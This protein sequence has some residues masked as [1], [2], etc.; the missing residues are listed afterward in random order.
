MRDSRAFTFD[1]FIK[2]EGNRLA[3]AV[4]EAVAETP[5]KAYNPLF[6]HGDVGLGK[7]HLLHAIAHAA[8]ERQNA[9]AIYV[10]SERFTIDLTQAIHQKRN[11]EFRNVYRQADILLLDDVHF[12][13]NKRGIS[14]E[15][16]HT[17]NAL[18]ERGHQIVLSSDR[19]PDELTTMQSR[20]VSRF[21]GG[22]VADIRPPDYDIRL[23][24]LRAKAA[25]N[26]FQVSEDLLEQIARRVTSNVRA[27]E[28]ALIR[29]VA[30]ADLCGQPLT[31]DQAAQLIPDDDRDVRPL[32]L[33]VIKV[34]VAKHYRLNPD[35][36][37][38]KR[39]DRTSTHVRQIAMYLARELTD[40]SYPAI[41]QAFGGRDHSTAMHACRQAELLLQ[42][43][44]FRGEIE[45][46]RE[47][48]RRLRLCGK[49][50]A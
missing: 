34:E 8:R 5:G 48:L 24:I 20:L 10:T 12:L 41:G 6:I 26:G 45:Q 42:T 35:Q 19:P 2:G 17:F 7:T 28:G 43:E 9:N 15:L 39:R 36:L 37:E 27:L 16:F 40:S 14:E 3:C 33:D 31:A 23:A 1:R 47:R 50:A 13:E 49:A 25:M 46:L 11:S 4:C 22:M 30:H 29:V 32:S 44:L 21:Q 18:Y 38:G